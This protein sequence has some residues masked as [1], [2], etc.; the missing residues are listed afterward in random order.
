MIITKKK[1]QTIV[2]TLRKEGDTGCD[3]LIEG[4]N[5]LLEKKKKILDF[6]LAKDIYRELALRHDKTEVA[7]MSSIRRAIHKVRDNDL[8]EIEF[9]NCEK[10]TVRKFFIN[11]YKYCKQVKIK[12]V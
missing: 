4:I 9:D 3:Y 6:S 2:E 5:V 12:Q 11:M 1:V 10:I 8:I 7:I